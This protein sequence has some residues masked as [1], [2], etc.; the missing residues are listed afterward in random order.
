MDLLALFTGPDHLFQPLCCPLWPG[1]LCVSC[2]PSM[3]TP[4]RASALMLQASPVCRYNIRRLQS[5]AGHELRQPVIA[6]M[7]PPTPL[8]N[9]LS[10]LGS[11]H[12]LHST[13]ALGQDV[14][15]M[16]WCGAPEHAC[17]ARPCLQTGP[18]AP[19]KTVL[20]SVGLGVETCAADRIDTVLSLS[21]WGCWFG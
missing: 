13:P 3:F 8:L 11:T 21:P 1:Y 6:G 10:S 4:G 19:P 17:G 18:A 15:Q 20:C 2:P 9:G 16:L 7:H 12:R 5:A 14:G